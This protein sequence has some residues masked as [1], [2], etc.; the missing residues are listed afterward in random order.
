MRQNLREERRRERSADE[1]LARLVD[2][3]WASIDADDDPEHQVTPD[4]E[5]YG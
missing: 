2:N 1:R 5:I 4:E 3:F